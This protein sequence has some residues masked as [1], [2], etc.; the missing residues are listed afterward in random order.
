MQLIRSA[1]VAIKVDSHVKSCSCFLRQKIIVDVSLHK[2]GMFIFLD[3]TGSDQRNTLRK[4]DYSM[5]GKPLQNHTLLARGEHMSGLAF[6]SVCGLLDVKGT[7]NG[8][9]FYNFVQK[10]LPHLIPFDG[11]NCQCGGSTIAPYT[12]LWKS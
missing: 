7:V 2:P 5:H 3:K 11:I 8:D 6:M 9:T 1:T 12:T 4:C 10:Y